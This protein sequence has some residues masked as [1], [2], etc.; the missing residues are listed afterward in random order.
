MFPSPNMIWLK[1]RFVTEGWTGWTFSYFLTFNFLRLK[2]SRQY[3]YQETLLCEISPILNLIKIKSEELDIQFEFRTCIKSCI[4]RQRHVFSK[5][6]ENFRISWGGLYN[7][8][9]VKDLANI[10]SPLYGCTFIQ[11][12]FSCC[13]SQL[14]GTPH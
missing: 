5:K 13:C 11:L 10:R 2:F 14:L 9:K 12:I 8:P 7:Q 3:A 6:D 1:S 4:S